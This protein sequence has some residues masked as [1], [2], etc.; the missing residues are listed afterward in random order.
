MS[1]ATEWKNI[2]C[3]IITGLRGEVAL[4]EEAISSIVNHLGNAFAVNSAALYIKIGRPGCE[5]GVIRFPTLSSQRSP[6]SHFENIDRSVASASSDYIII[7]PVQSA[8]VIRSPKICDFHFYY[9]V[10]SQNWNDTE[11]NFFTKN[12]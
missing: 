11:L 1:V 9:F 5:V 4:N 7:R 10:T 2:S 8:V 12:K 6:G 3:V